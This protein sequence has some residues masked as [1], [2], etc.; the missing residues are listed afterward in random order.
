MVLHPPL[1]KIAHFRDVLPGQSLG[2][3]LKKLNLT[4]QKQTKQEHNDKNTKSELKSKE[5]RQT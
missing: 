3:V 2:V 5:N 4:Q 1:H